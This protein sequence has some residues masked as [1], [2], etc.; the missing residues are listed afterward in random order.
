MKTEG[1][2]KIK[3]MTA[4]SHVISS[5]ICG[6]ADTD[7]EFEQTAAQHGITV[8]RTVL[9]VYETAVE[10]YRLMNCK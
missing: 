8:F 10:I 2:L 1:I 9:P 7:E 6:D 4:V 3:G 5:E